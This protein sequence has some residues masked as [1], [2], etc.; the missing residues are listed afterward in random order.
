M[1]AAF[2]GFPPQ[3]P[4][5]GGDGLDRHLLY[6]SSS[7]SAPFSSAVAYDN[8]VYAT[9]SAGG[10]LTV[11]TVDV[12]GVTVERSTVCATDD[13]NAASGGI[14]MEVVSGACIVW[15]MGAAKCAPVLVP[16][17]LHGPVFVFVGEVLGRY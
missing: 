10:T 1:Y 15:V 2:Q 8:V 14:V 4:A 16:S 13:G 9:L 6:V 11:R 5:T 7:P 17:Q 12:N 3:T